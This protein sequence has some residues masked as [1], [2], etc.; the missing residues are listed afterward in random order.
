[1][2]GN[3]ELSCPISFLEEWASH[4]FSVDTVQAVVTHKLSLSTVPAATVSLIFGSG[5]MTVS[6]VYN[7][8]GS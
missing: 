2:E 7:A 8:S 4:L 1:M 5:N 3:T 6:T